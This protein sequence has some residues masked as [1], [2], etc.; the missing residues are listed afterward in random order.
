MENGWELEEIRER[1]LYIREHSKDA[2]ITHFANG[3]LDLLNVFIKRVYGRTDK[4]DRRGTKED[5]QRV[6]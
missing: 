2:T 6:R 1:L 4:E 3:S 5:Q